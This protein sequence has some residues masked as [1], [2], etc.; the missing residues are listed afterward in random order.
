MGM[1]QMDTNVF[2]RLDVQRCLSKKQKWAKVE[3]WEQTCPEILVPSRF[4]LHG[5]EIPV[6]LSELR[7]RQVEARRAQ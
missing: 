5:V 4:S 1:G 7:S 2:G 6:D 3:V